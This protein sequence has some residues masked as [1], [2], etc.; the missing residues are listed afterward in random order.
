[1]VAKVNLGKR[2]AAD[3]MI[4]REKNLKVAN[5][6]FACALKENRNSIL[7]GGGRFLEVASQLKAEVA[8]LNVPEPNP[9]ELP[10]LIIRRQDLVVAIGF[11]RIDITLRPADHV[12]NS[13][14]SAIEHFHGTIEPVLP[15]LLGN[16]WQ[17]EWSGIIAELEYQGPP[18]MVRGQERATPLFDR[19]LRIDR[20]GRPL[21]SFEL[22]FGYEEGGFNRNFS[23]QGYEIKKFPP[24]PIPRNGIVKINMD[25]LPIDT[26]GIGVI[27]DINNKPAK[28]RFSA[29][30]EFDALIQEHLRTNQI[31]ETELGLAGEM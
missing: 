6:Q 16:D 14:T 28:S 17:Y 22:K 3:S 24:T 26:S 18:P 11:S 20:K 25:K 15:L 19:L 27:V 2:S 4:W 5:F 30:Q 29:L 1:M 10:R 21:A 23:L 12:A 7:A 9:P 13:F 31:L 8:Q